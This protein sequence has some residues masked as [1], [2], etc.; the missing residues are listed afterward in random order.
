MSKTAD[1]IDIMQYCKKFPS[2]GYA[3]QVS[4]LLCLL[5]NSLLSE[6]CE[7]I[8]VQGAIWFNLNI[9]GCTKDL[10]KYLAFVIAVFV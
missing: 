10:R 8:L 9:S 1:M 6:S 2:A 5:G 3:K 4:H 7:N